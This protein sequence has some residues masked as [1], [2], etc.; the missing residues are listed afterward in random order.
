MVS[1]NGDGELENVTIK[2][3]I[4]GEESVLNVA[5]VFVGVGIKP[6][7]DLLRTL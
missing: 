6:G 7:T 5:G 1:F 4:T 2:N 3:K